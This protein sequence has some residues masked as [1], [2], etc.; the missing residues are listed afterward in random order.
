MRARRKLS[1]P[2]EGR[3]YVTIASPLVATVTHPLT[4][5]VDG[6]TEALFQ[7]GGHG[8]S[9]QGRDGPPTSTSVLLSVSGKRKAPF[10]SK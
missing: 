2:D 6:E 7:G 4:A 1:S 5:T 8:V 10:I 9:E 3:C